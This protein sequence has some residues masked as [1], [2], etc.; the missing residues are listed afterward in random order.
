MKF[1]KHIAIASAACML[2]AGA[3]SPAFALPVSAE[4]TQQNPTSGTYKNITWSF[5]E[6]SKTLT[7]SGTGDTGSYY[8]TVSLLSVDGCPWG[9][10]CNDIE[11]IVVSEGITK[12]G[13]GL[14]A[15][16]YYVKSVQLPESLTA[17]G[18]SA[19][20]ECC[21]LSE[22]NIPE[23]VTEFGASAFYD[24]AWLN[25]RHSQKQMRGNDHDCF[26][27]EN[28]V[29]I[30]GTLYGSY[31]RAPGNP[32]A[33]LSSG[34]LKAIGGGAFQSAEYIGDVEVP[35]SSG[36]DRIGDWAF[37]RS[38]ITSLTLSKNITRIGVDICYCCPDL[39]KVTIENPLL[40]IPAGATTFCNT[41]TGD[42]L[43]NGTICGYTDST[44]QAYAEKNDYKFESI[45]DALPVVQ[46]DFNYDETV[47]LEDAQGV[48]EYY[49]K[50][51]AGK[52]PLIAGTQKK[53]AD[54]NSD[55][56][57]DVMDAQYILKYYTEKD[58]AKK[59]VTW[60]E[61]LK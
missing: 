23:S 1:R 19:F 35:D 46:G 41:I 50:T 17:I 60:E 42:K 8:N 10:F 3:A 47:T 15:F 30:D 6:A 16:H 28:G 21:C 33:A 39:E 11:K 51:F 40:E 13:V 26:I 29:L 5:D 56:A 12:I 18:E 7:V 55:G 37:E 57:A 58:V 59:A 38:S 45:G 9:A 44:A 53:C 48:L 27:A 54:V 14:F 61:I 31:S 52:E 22:I 4:E 43:F 24:T 36:I 2:L 25:I 32:A 49:T 34:K 20:A